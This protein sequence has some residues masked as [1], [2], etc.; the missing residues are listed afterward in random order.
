MV[1]VLPGFVD[2]PCIGVHVTSLCSLEIELRC[3]LAGGVAYCGVLWLIGRCL[4]RVQCRLLR[5]SLCLLLGQLL[6]LL[7]LL[8]QLYLLHQLPDFTL[9]FLLLHC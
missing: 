1:R 4:L 7:L 9:A 8:L 2:R 6:L 3:A 5:S